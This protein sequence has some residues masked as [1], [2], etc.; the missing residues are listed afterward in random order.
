[1]SN[2]GLTACPCCGQPVEPPSSSASGRP[3]DPLG[4]I[5]GLALHRLSL[6]S[7]RMLL[8]LQ[9]EL[10]ELMESPGDL[11]AVV[12]VPERWAGFTKSRRRL[13][14]LALGEVLARTVTL[15]VRRDAPPIDA[16][17]LKGSPMAD[18]FSSSEPPQTP[19]PPGTPRSRLSD[20][21]R[22]GVVGCGVSSAAIAKA[23]RR[24]F[25]TSTQRDP[26]EKGPRVYSYREV[27]LCL[28]AA[29]YHT[30]D[31]TGVIEAGAL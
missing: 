23:Y 2:N 16:T 1:M 10:V 9:S 24:L 30:P 6:P 18:S 27:C 21:T 22:L 26:A 19:C 8:S 4:L 5:W 11:V 25:G 3:V 15:E 13:L 7:T 14:E 31:T 12:E 17:G 20:W 28:P 29:G